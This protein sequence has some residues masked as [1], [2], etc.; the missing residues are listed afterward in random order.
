MSTAV[1]AAAVVQK[2][3][4]L[5]EKTQDDSR[6]VLTKKSLN[7]KLHAEIERSFHN[8]FEV[9]GIYFSVALVDAVK[10]ALGSNAN[11]YP[12]AVL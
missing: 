3:F 10:T 2:C 9:V 8:K 1:A 12:E 4:G 5:I 11:C 6:A 7:G